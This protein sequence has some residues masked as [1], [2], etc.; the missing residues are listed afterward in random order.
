MDDFIKAS[1]PNNKLRLLYGASHRI[2][3]FEEIPLFI[4]AGFEVIPVTIHWDIFKTQEPGADDPTHP[5][6]PN[7]KETCSLSEEIIKKIQSIDL[8]K[9]KNLNAESGRITKAQADLLNQYIDIIYIPNLLP[10]APRILTWFKGLTLFRIYGEGKIMTY[11]EWAQ[12]SGVNLK[13]LKQYDQR[14]IA[15]LMLHSLNGI[16]HQ[17]ILGKNIFHVSPCVSK[18]R[19]P[20]R[21]KA[22]KATKIC[23]TALSYIHENPHWTDIYREFSSLFQDTPIRFLGKNNKNIPELKQDERVTGMIADEIEY[24]ELLTDCRC[25]IDPG[26]SPFHTHYTPLEAIHMGIPVIFLESSGMAQEI[27]RIIPKSELKNCGMCHDFEEMK[28]I[29][30]NCLNDFVFAKTISEK[31]NHIAQQLFSP[32][33]TL[34]QI[35]AFANAAPELLTQAHALAI[36]KKAAKKVFLSP[37]TKM[38]NVFLRIRRGILNRIKRLT[39]FLMK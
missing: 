5:L 32:Q 24:L 9:Y 7:W 17:S 29:V 30:T 1:K 33:S 20:K 13:T 16:E 28:H 15:M 4:Q 27:L 8:F 6:Y 14:Y 36:D 2:L 26:S 39:Q 19:L 21:W 38:L 10:A 35:Q 37:K 18:S 23:N 3:R 25:L 12:Q 34:K 31:Q 11:D 22:E